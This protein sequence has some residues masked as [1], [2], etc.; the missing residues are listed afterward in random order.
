MK[1][2]FV[3]EALKRIRDDINVITLNADALP[4]CAA[5]T[6]IGAVAKEASKDVWNLLADFEKVLE[7]EQAA[8]KDKEVK[9][10]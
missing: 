5:A 6:A 10:P 9:A 3:V 1:T 8:P 2:Q 4:H 7:Q